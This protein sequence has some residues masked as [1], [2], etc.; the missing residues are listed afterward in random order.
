MGHASIFVYLLLDLSIIIVAARTCG[1]IA[2]QLGQPAV[3]GEVVAGIILGPTLLGRLFPGLPALIFPPDVPLKQIADLGLVFFMFLVGLE[4]NTGL[5]RKQAGKSVIISAFG[6]ALPFVLGIGL[7]FQLL[8]LNNAGNFSAGTSHPPEAMVFALFMGAAMCITAFPILARFLAET[9]LY[10][11][12][13]GVTALCAAAVDDVIAWVLLAAVIGIAKNGS[14]MAAWQGILLTIVFA[15]FLLTIGRRLLEM[16]AKRYDTTGILTVDQVAIVVT[17]VLLS[18]MFT[19]LIGIHAIFGAFLFGVAMPKR[20]GM[21]HALTDRIE[22]FTSIVLLP[23]FFCVVGL[24]TNLLTLDSASLLG[25][26]LIILAVAV[27]GKLVGTGAAAWLT[28]S[29]RRES[30]VIGTLMNTRGLTELVI[31][32]IGL[33]LGVLSDQV[34][35]MM[36]IMALTTTIVA[37]PI[38]NR[39]IKRS[40]TMGFLVQATAAHS[41]MHIPIPEDAAAPEKKPF[42]ILVAIGNPEN[43]PALMDAAIR[44]SGG[45]GRV[46]LLLVKLIHSPRAPEVRSGL[47]DEDDRV[48]AV[49]SEM[50]PLMRRAGE[51]GVSARPISFLTTNLGM[52]LAW[53]SADQS[54]DLLLLGWNRARLEK[55]I[56]L[57]LVYRA[58]V[59]APCDVAVLVDRF[60]NGIHPRSDR[61]VL[62]LLGG[63]VHDES[64]SAYASSLAQN[65][66]TALQVETVAS[67]DSSRKAAADAMADAAAAV[68]VVGDDW[69]LQKDFG[70][71]AGSLVKEAQCPVL[72]LRAANWAEK[73]QNGQSENRKWPLGRRVKSL[74]AA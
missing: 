3:I 49:L 11:A 44:L 63:G 60:G 50:Q 16:L 47:L 40:D 66:A 53:I 17:G 18:A 71:P 8:P 4:L 19:E 48:S 35:A 38:V 42:R 61:P 46:E 72:V 69:V 20:A 13:V 51:L 5:L 25:W 56:L 73:V 21:T 34:M 7:G 14:L 2:K 15:A 41:H 57:S 52:D 74:N 30:L 45:R 54:C 65:L 31:L 29:T 10:K 9:G 55:N 6:I 36:V 37:A 43:A 64:A 27:L 26:T 59:T 28:G 70:N 39:L 33:Q 68:V 67:S 12:P 22:D 23:V 58:F 32:S 62:A 1:A 24:R